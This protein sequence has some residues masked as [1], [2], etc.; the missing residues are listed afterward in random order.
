MA[1]H[2]DLLA[3]I[4]RFVRDSVINNDDYKNKFAFTRTN[5]QLFGLTRISKLTDDDKIENID[6]I[7]IDSTKSYIILRF[8]DSGLIL[9]SNKLEKGNIEK[10]K[11]L[12]LY[13]RIFYGF[14]SKG[15]IIT[16][17][18]IQIDMDVDEKGQV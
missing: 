4:N 11:T 17:P 12:V 2:E 13:D 8:A 14:N 9:Q 15:E 7:K 18:E 5:F 10:V 6:F 16:K 3:S 1:A